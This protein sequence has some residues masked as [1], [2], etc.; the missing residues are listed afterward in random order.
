MLMTWVSLD[1]LEIVSAHNRLVKSINR[2]LAHAVPWYVPK[3]RP[4]DLAIL[5]PNRYAHVHVLCVGESPGVRQCHRARALAVRLRGHLAHPTLTIDPSYALVQERYVDRVG[6]FT[7]Q[8]SKMSAAA[9]LQRLMAA[10]GLSPCI[11]L[12]CTS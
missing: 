9:T 6:C 3:K 1:S 5:A 4:V 11:S 12:T 10:L 8:G 2:V 7:N